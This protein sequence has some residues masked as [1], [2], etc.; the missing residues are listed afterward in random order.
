MGTA[1]SC[2]PAAL[3]DRWKNR[4][5]FP[6]GDQPATCT[7]SRFGARY[8][9]AGGP[10]S[11]CVSTTTL[12]APTARS[13][14]FGAHATLDAPAETAVVMLS[15]RPPTSTRPDGGTPAT[16]APAGDHDNEAAAQGRAG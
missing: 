3:A 6:P 9:T 2:A 10:P 16:A 4:I 8:S 1:L 5:Q 7:V 14:P 13:R 12:R 11:R 15:P